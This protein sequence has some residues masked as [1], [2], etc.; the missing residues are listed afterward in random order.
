M[1]TF[2]FDRA[3]G[4]SILVLGAG[5]TGRSAVRWFRAK[6]ADVS[7]WDS[8]SDTPNLSY[9]Q[10]YY[11]E[12]RCLSGNL[13]DLELSEFLF[14]VVSPGIPLP[15]GFI[16]RAATHD[17]PIFGDVEIFLEI[18]RADLGA[19]VVAITGTNGKTTVTS[20][21]G[22]ILNANSISSAT[23]GNIGLPVL[24]VLSSIEE[25]EIEKPEVF[26]LEVSSFQ[27]ALANSFESDISVVT[28]IS[29]D[30]L[31]RHGSMSDYV[32]AKSRVFMGSGTSIINRDDPRILN[33]FP[34]IGQRVS[35][36]LGAPTRDHE[37]G[38][39]QKEGEPWLSKFETPLIRCSD[40]K[41]IG[42]HNQLNALVALAICDCIVPTNPTSLEAICGF[43]GLDHRMQLVSS[44]NGVRFINDSKGTNVGATRAA[45]SSMDGGC[46]LIVG[47]LSKGQDFSHLLS[48]LE[49]KTRAVVLFGQDK[50]RIRESLHNF[51][52]E[53][54]LAETLADAVSIAVERCDTGDTVLFS[55]A[56]ASFD[57]FEDY[58][59]RG[60]IF[61]EIVRGMKINSE[62][63]N[64][65]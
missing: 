26:V 3:A 56:C 20:M 27:L 41:V 34:E 7:L 25:G 43:I 38:I 17:I 23:V 1:K 2:S 19:K 33:M 8:Q 58:R 31:D 57:M 6:G 64:V 22:H 55:P 14:V 47:G 61:S 62:S 60:R 52:V 46:V 63:V 45:L 59:D 44:I 54:A 48:G 37:W 49:E 4:N 24:D 39:E 53:L 51:D 12:V 10:T 5:E 18:N 13:P 50:E 42:Y 35:I 21:V 65:D 9:V 40:L 11:P 32:A 30:H 36:G 15:E 28:N 29:E 16:N